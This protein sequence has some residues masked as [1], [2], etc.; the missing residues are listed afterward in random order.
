MPPVQKIYDSKNKYIT[1]LDK[2]YKRNQAFYEAILKNPGKYKLNS[3]DES[4]NKILTIHL[5]KS[6]LR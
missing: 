1:W 6:L 4:L 3:E 2:E 5:F